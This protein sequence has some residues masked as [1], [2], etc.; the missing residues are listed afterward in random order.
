MGSPLHANT[1]HVTML[2]ARIKNKGVA[3]EIS[4]NKTENSMPAAVYVSQ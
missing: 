4:L 2:K 3:I 1:P